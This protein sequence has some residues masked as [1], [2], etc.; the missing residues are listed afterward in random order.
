MDMLFL[1]TI[2]KSNMMSENRLENAEWVLML[3]NVVSLVSMWG[4]GIGIFQAVGCLP[5]VAS[6]TV[7]WD[8]RLGIPNFIYWM[9]RYDVQAMIGSLL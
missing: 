6:I 7:I 3:Y 8:L 5:I 4:S 2:W 1:S 9:N